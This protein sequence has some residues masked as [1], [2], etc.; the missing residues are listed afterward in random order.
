VIQKPFLRKEKTTMNN[1]SKPD[2]GDE[3]KIDKE[4][5][6]V[7][8]EDIERLLMDCPIP[9][10]LTE[11][12]YQVLI[13]AM[14]SLKDGESLDFTIGRDGSVKI[15]NDQKMRIREASILGVP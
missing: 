13:E 9:E 12:G 10:H 15:K 1:E 5:G 7:S 4:S 2:N 6:S 8:R 11:E 3:V 14:K